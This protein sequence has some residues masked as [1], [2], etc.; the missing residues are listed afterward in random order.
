M[1]SHTPNDATRVESV[2]QLVEYMLEGAK[3][4]ERWV[5]GTEHEKLGWYPRATP[6]P[7]DLYPAY[8]GDAGIG[9]LL[10]A[11]EAGAGWEATREGDAIIALAR[12]RATITLE[13]GGQLELS[14]APLRTLAE[15]GAELMAHL[16]EVRAFSEPLGLA[17]S[18]L[19]CAPVGRPGDMPHMPKARYGVMRRYLPTRGAS[20]LRMMHQTCT[21]QAN[22]DFADAADAMRKLRASL[23]VQP[24]VTALFAN[25]PFFDGR[26]TGERSHRAEV[27]LATD[28]DR[29]VFP[30]SLLEA[31]AD[32]RDYVE[33]ALDVPMFFVHRGDAYIDNAGMTFRRFLQEGVRDCTGGEQCR[34]NVGDFALHLSTLFPDARIKQHLEVRGADMGDA[35]HVLALPALHLGLLYDDAALA[36][37]LS[38]LD[39]IDYEAWWSLRRAVPTEALEARVK[40]ASDEARVG[41]LAKEVLRLARAGLERVE[42][43]AADLLAPLD[44]TVTTGLTPADR[45]L[46]SW[47]GDVSALFEATRL[48]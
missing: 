24:I 1:S 23:L 13:P 26:P 17:W 36:G 39:G 18:G 11:L 46:A 3:P 27:W 4:R 31:G 35:A 40:V 2:E 5:V 7:G 25:S 37:L 19:G 42:P 20:A 47:D 9:A 12:D 38:L 45:L 29:V 30:R 33:W 22:Y 28:D 8:G 48:A 32:L 34:A 44:E 43:G 21:V 14:G 6:S 41:E 16:E 15:T 10:S